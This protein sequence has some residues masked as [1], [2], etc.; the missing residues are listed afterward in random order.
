MIHKSLTPKREDAWDRH[1]TGLFQTGFFFNSDVGLNTAIRSWKKT[2]LLYCICNAK[3]WRTGN[4]HLV[5]NVHNGL[6]QL[7]LREA[8]EMS[9]APRTVR[10]HG[11]RHK[12]PANK[13]IHRFFVKQFSD[14]F[15]RREKGKKKPE[16]RMEKRRG[17]SLSWRTRGGKKERCLGTLLTLPRRCF[18]QS[19]SRCAPRSST[20]EDPNCKKKNK[21]AWDNSTTSS[22]P[23]PRSSSRYG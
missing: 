9:A 3:R 22:L 21:T 6:A 5:Q 14:N 15:K 2:L 23:F 8:G 16:V 13:K 7:F 12:L 20:T 17:L 11:F 1:T 19:A 18:E 4:E 10:L